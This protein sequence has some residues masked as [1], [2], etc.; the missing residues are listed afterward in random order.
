MMYL[1][2]IGNGLYYLVQTDRKYSSKCTIYKKTSQFK[3]TLF[4]LK[5][6]KTIT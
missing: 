5:H 2:K 6:L 1:K 4:H 3:R